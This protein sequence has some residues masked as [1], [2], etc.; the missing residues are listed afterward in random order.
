[1]NADISK[2][3]IKE[4]PAPISVETKEPD[5]DKQRPLFAWLPADIIK[6]TY[7][8]TTQYARIP[9]STLLRKRYMSPN[10][11]CNVHRRDKNVATDTIFSD[12]PA[13]DCGVTSAQFFV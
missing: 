9:M 2:D 13:V 3:E 5:Y 12:T 8:L 10:P 1:M 7:E 6:K 4:T 11:A